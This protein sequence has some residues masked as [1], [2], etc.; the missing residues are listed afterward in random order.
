MFNPD[1]YFKVVE[2]ESYFVYGSKE[3]K[4]WEVVASRYEFGFVQSR[5]E[6]R[7]VVKVLNTA[8]AEAMKTLNV[9][10]RLGN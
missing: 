3:R 4:N 2:G 10:I 9:T 5:E 8:I 7:E 1:K 6:A